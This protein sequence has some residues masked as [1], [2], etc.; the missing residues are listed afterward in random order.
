MK[1]VLVSLVLAAMTVGLLATPAGRQ[2]DVELVHRAHA[3]DRTIPALHVFMQLGTSIGD[4][5]PLLLGALTT[6]AF[7]TPAA[8]ATAGVAFVAVGANQVLTGLIKWIVN[9]ERPDL[10]LSPRANSSF[11]SGHASASVGLAY[12]LAHRHRRLTFWVW[13]CA[14]WISVSRVFLER[15][16]PSDVVAGAL[17]GILMAVVVLR[18]E[19]RL[20]ALTTRGSVP[21]PHAG[22]SG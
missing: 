9:R 16:Y 15:H 12:V 20:A 5:R 2:L 14:I 21:P 17:I 6:A 18:F 4:H 19:D 11:P 13:A 7:G 10:R 22:H 1:V 3:L 8:R